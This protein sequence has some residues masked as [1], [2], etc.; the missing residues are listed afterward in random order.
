MYCNGEQQEGNSNGIQGAQAADSDTD[1]AGKDVAQQTAG[2]RQQTAGQ[3]VSEEMLVKYIAKSTYKTL[4]EEGRKEVE[5]QE[6][7]S[8]LNRTTTPLHD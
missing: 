4:R 1:S 8:S 2:S 6:N 7:N 3:R 5:E